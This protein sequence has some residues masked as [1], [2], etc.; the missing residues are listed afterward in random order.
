MSTRPIDRR[1]DE[2]PIIPINRKKGIHGSIPD[3]HRV[4]RLDIARGITEA[5]QSYIAQKVEEE[6]KGR[7]PNTTH[8]IND[9][10]E[11][12][13]HLTSIVQKNTAVRIQ[14]KTNEQDRLDSAEEESILG[15]FAPPPS[16]IQ[17]D[18]FSNWKIYGTKPDGEE[19][20]SHAWANAIDRNLLHLGVDPEDSRF[21]YRNNSGVNELRIDGTNHARYNESTTD[22]LKL[23]V[24]K[25]GTV[26][27][28]RNT[29]TTIWCRRE[30]G[31]DGTNFNLTIKN[32]SNLFKTYPAETP[33][34]CGFGNYDITWRHTGGGEVAIGVEPL[35]PIREDNIVLEDWDAGGFA[36]DHWV[37]FKAII[38][39]NLIDNT[40]TLEGWT[41]N[42]I[43]TRSDPEAWHKDIEFT[44]TGTNVDIDPTG[45]EA[46]VTAC[47][48]KGSGTA[49]DLDGLGTLFIN[50]GGRHV[51]VQTQ[52]FKK[53]RFKWF[54]IREITPLQSF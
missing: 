47:L 22:T 18:D 53:V 29:E 27:D 38:R 40:I 37:G 43:E 10:K 8:D 44:F 5:T 16:P 17:L 21:S 30:Q 48:N 45:N 23:I 12:V 35:A 52:N 36:V 39:D 51:W 1:A 54:S 42:E 49:N 20:F 26:V 7:A 25:G 46:R 13:N 24:E 28:W 33:N 34:D 9:L 11:T 3:I 50:R 4:I 15:S 2:I 14:T 32:R 31:D 19:W 41:N 6:L